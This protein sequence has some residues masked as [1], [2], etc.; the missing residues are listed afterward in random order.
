MNDL[1]KAAMIKSVIA[2][3]KKNDSITNREC[4]E[5]LGIA[6]DHVIK[7]LGE[8]TQSGVL[9]RIGKGSGTKYVLNE[10]KQ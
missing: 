9:N 8:M 2:Y 5:L 3:I 1:E 6:Y 10:V 4:R 7:L